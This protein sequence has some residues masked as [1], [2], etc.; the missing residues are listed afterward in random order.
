VSLS[1]PPAPE[2]IGRPRR[3]DVLD[4]L[5]EGL[6]W[7]REHEPRS[8]NTVLNACRAWRFAACGDWLSKRAAEAWV[9]RVSGSGA[10]SPDAVLERAAAALEAAV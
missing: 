6:R 10:Q 4:A 9:R 2:V 1:G 8:P 7:S 5:I 3:E